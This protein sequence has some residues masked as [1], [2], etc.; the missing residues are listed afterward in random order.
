AAPSPYSFYKDNGSPCSAHLSTD[1]CGRKDR[2]L[3]RRYPAAVP[4]S[5]PSAVPVQI[6]DHLLN[7]CHSV[8]F[9]YASRQYV[10]FSYKHLK[11]II[12]KKRPNKNQ[13]VVFWSCRI[14]MMRSSNFLS[15]RCRR[16]KA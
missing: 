13:G 14:V 5:A 6:S 9:R 15:M 4:Q 3:P 2:P 12:L 8:S 7:L 11:S 16:K 10:K 1:C